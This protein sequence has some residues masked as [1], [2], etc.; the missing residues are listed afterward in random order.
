MKILENHA[1]VL[2]HLFALSAWTAFLGL[3]GL[4]TT[5]IPAFYTLGVVAALAVMVLISG[6]RR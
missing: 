2:F 6:R 1:L 5:L 4:D 3:N